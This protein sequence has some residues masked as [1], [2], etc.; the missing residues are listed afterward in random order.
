MSKSVCSSGRE[1]FWI[2]IG[3]RSVRSSSEQNL[4]SLSAGRQQ[5]FSIPG[6][7]NRR[8]RNR[9]RISRNSSLQKSIH[10][11]GNCTYVFSLS[12]NFEYKRRTKVIGTTIGY[13]KI[14]EKLGGGI[15]GAGYETYDPKRIRLNWFE[16]SPKGIDILTEG[17]ALGSN[18]PNIITTLKGLNT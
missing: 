3:R 18:L 9:V 17:N 5:P 4:Q 14:Y 11:S 8:Y 7:S 1:R 16:S 12:I 15:L 6:D 13:Y 2:K 10:R